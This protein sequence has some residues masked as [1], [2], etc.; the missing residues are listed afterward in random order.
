MIH[1]EYRPNN[2]TTEHMK[3]DELGNVVE[4]IDPLGYS[5]LIT[6]TD[7]FCT[8][9]SSG[10]CTNTTS[11]NT[12]AFPTVVTNALSQATYADFDYNTGLQTRSKNVRGFI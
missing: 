11:H 3:Y 5:T 9:D 8:L 2:Y 10:N 6:Y 4:K 12:Y 1:G 7:S